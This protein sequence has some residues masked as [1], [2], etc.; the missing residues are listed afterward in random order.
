MVLALSTHTMAAVRRM[1]ELLLTVAALG[2]L[3]G[4]VAPRRLL[5]MD[6]ALVPRPPHMAAIRGVARRLPTEPLLPHPGRVEAIRG[7]TLLARAVLAMMLPLPVLT[8]VHLPRLRLML[9]PR[10]HTLLPR[11][12]RSVLRLLVLGKVDGVRILRLHRP[13]VRRH[14]LPVVVTTVPRRQVRMEVLRRLPEPAVHDIPMMIEGEKA[15]V[16]CVC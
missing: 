2:L 14:L 1:A 11:R 6:S 15:R 7:D 5:Q 12:L 13:L 16:M 3:P 4:P 10:A 9:L 8:L